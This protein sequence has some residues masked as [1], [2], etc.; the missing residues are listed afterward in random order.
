ML[1]NLKELLQNPQ[2]QANIKVATDKAAI[3]ELLLTA[4]VEKGYA[5]TIESINN[6]LA[7]LNPIANELSEDDLLVVSGGKPAK[8]KNCYTSTSVRYCE[9]KGGCS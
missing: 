8:T 4:S 5:F 7:E 6:F 2:L 1:D 3:I 9:E